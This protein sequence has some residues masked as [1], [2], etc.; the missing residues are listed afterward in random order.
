MGRVIRAAFARCARHLRRAGYV[1]DKWMRYDGA[2]LGLFVTRPAGT[3]APRPRP[4]SSGGGKC[5]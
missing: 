1:T 5:R 3:R 4:G 2:Q